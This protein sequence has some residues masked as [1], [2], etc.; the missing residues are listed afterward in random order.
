MDGSAEEAE[1]PLSNMQ[2]VS[3]GSYITDQYQ[4]A[5]G[6]FIAATIQDA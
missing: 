3:H 5:C 1:V 2:I 6:C 4:T